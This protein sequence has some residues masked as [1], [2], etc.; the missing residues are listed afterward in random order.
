MTASQPFTAPSSGWHVT[1]TDLR[2]YVAGDVHGVSAD[3]IEAHLLR[4]DRCRA[5][6]AANAPT[7]DR[8]RRW[9]AITAEVDQP[10]RWARN[11][12]W[13]RVALGTPHL[14][15]AL[16]EAKPLIQKWAWTTSG[17]SPCQRSARPVANVPM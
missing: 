12:T 3:S 10:G 5:T 17:R 2:A 9:E 13:F 14:A 7:I 16:I 4:C 1:T 8:D 6:L 15:A 11:A